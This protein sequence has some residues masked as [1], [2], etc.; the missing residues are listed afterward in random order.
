MPCRGTAALAALAA[1]GIVAPAHGFA[2]CSGSGLALLRSHVVPS[3]SRRRGV[4]TPPLAAATMT[5]DADE[6]KGME[7]RAVLSRVAVVAAGLAVSTLSA[8]PAVLAAAA[9]KKVVVAGATGQTGRRILERL[10]S[11]PGL[12]VVGGKVN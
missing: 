11:S 8:P 3:P 7:R 2:P 4:A 9:P 5:A 12:T 1:L 10:A 6:Y